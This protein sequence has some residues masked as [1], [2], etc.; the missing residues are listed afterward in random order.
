MVACTKSNTVSV[1]PNVERCVC[2]PF[3][4]AAAWSLPH[5]SECLR[6]G[7][8]SSACSNVCCRIACLPPGCQINRFCCGYM[9]ADQVLVDE[10]HFS[11]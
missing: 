7:V 4:M 3:G 6:L 9:I 5:R 2:G 1:V 10:M 11:N 8:L